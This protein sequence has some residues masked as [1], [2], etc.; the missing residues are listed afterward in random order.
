[1][2]IT[3]ILIGT[4]ISFCLSEIDAYIQE[5]SFEKDENEQICNKERCIVIILWPFILWIFIKA[6]FE[7]S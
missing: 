2:I 7:K 3:Y 5:N 4:F 6:L 1:M